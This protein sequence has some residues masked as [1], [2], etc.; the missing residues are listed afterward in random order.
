M[1][2]QCQLQCHGVCAPFPIQ[3]LTLP[4]ACTDRAAKLFL[5]KERSQ[6]FAE[7]LIKRKRRQQPLLISVE[8]TS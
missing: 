2:L 5:Q 4:V 7:G 6:S 8:L 3:A 1:T